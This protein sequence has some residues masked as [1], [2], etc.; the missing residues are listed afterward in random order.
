[1]SLIGAA[2]LIIGSVIIN[3]VENAEMDKKIETLGSSRDQLDKD[4]KNEYESVSADNTSAKKMTDD[5]NREKKSQD[6]EFNSKTWHD[7]NNHASKVSKSSTINSNYNSSLQ[8][9]LKDVQKE[10]ESQ[11]N[12]LTNQYQKDRD[13]I[14]KE[15]ISTES[16]K[17][18]NNS[19]FTFEVINDTMDN[20]I[21]M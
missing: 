14:T 11:L 9:G 2:A 1:M 19:E 5:L 18:K 10:K 8:K 15:L 13:S 20:T 3:S 4:Y 12:E 6:D 7:S 16:D 17:G 21:Y